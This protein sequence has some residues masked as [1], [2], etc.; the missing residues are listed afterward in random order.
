MTPEES[1]D[2][3]LR[4]PTDV[5]RCDIVEWLYRSL[6]CLLLLV[7]LVPLR[8]SVLVG[9]RLISLFYHPLLVLLLLLVLRI[10]LLV[11]LYLLVQL[12]RK[13]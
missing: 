2:L 13:H 3:S 8:T 5:R 6:S 12:R 4:L 7:D 9:L 11:L 10:Q 1:V